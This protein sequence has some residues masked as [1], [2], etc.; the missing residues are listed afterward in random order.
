MA[1]GCNT[2]ILPDYDQE[3]R[4]REQEVQANDKRRLRLLRER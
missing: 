3:Q 1:I 2:R 4:A